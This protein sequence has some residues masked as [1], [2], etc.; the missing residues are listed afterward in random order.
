MAH[1]I[2]DRRALSKEMNARLDEALE[3]G[4][5]VLV[6]IPGQGGSGIAGTDRRAFIW[7]PGIKPKILRAHPY[8]NLTGVAVGTG[9]IRSVQ[10]YGAGLD[11]RKLTYS[12]IASHTAA[13]TMPARSFRPESEQEAVRRLNEL[14]AAS[15]ATANEAYAFEQERL[16]LALTTELSE[17]AAVLC[18]E[19]G[20]GVAVASGSTEFTCIGC[21]SGYLLRRCPSCSQP[22]LCPASLAGEPLKCPKCGQSV[23]YAAW[24]RR[25]VTAGVYASASPVPPEYADPDLR[26]V[27]GEVWLATGFPRLTRG[28]SCQL[29]FQATQI[30]VL[31]AGATKGDVVASIPWSE[32]RTLEV[33]GAGA[34]T[35][36][37]GGGVVGGGFG[38]KGFVEGALIATA[39][40]ALTR[41][42]STTIETFMKVNAGSRE[43]MLLNTLL[44]PDMLRVRLAPAFARLAAAR[45]ADGVKPDV[46]PAGQ[47]DR[48]T[49]LKMLAELRDSGVLDQAEFQSEKARNSRLGLSPG[50]DSSSR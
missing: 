20:A 24:D 29:Q 40:N 44:T 45:G 47:V 6:A 8:V 35:K 5:R 10:L 19:C 4:E 7:K 43:V 14:A 42:T 12:N 1:A 39:I 17:Q 32:V 41:R 15:A 21:G 3:P 11:D 25:P 13:I 22:G 27:I 49:R 28:A 18:V 33:T 30:L 16:Q 2:D 48:L 38:L 46:S 37:T 26:V 31:I 23:A 36:T 34:I 9:R 50:H